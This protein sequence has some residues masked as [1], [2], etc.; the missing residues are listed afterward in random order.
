MKNAAFRLLAVAS[1]IAALFTVAPAVA[2]AGD[3][4]VIQSCSGTI[5]NPC[6][7]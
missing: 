2:A 4:V 1:L 3:D 7:D 5:N 6:D